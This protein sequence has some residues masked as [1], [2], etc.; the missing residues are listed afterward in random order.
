VEVSPGTT[1]GAI[2]S[3]IHLREIFHDSQV[4]TTIHAAKALE[5]VKEKPDRRDLS[6]MSEVSQAL[7]LHKPMEELLDY[8]MDIV[9]SQLPMDRSILMLWEG[10]PLQLIPKV[11][12]I[13]ERRLLNQKIL[14]SQS[15]VD[16]VIRDQLSVLTS[17]AM[18]DPRFMSRESII[19]SNIHSAMCVPLWNNKE[20]IGIIYSDR[21]TNPEKFTE[22]DLRLLTLL[23]NLAAVKIENAQLIENT[24]A[25]EKMEKEL[26]LASKIQKDFLPKCSPSLEHYEIEG[27][28]IP[29][30]QVGGDYFDYIEIDPVR[31]GI[32]IA[33]VSGKGVSASLL[34]ASLRAALYSEVHSRYKLS[35]MAL[36]LNGFVHRSSAP[37][38]FIT[39][40]F[41]E[42]DKETGKLSYVNAGHNPP[43]I[44]NAK[45]KVRRLESCG[46]CLGMFPDSTYE[47]KDASL[48][49]GDIALFFTDGVPDCRNKGN[50]E[51]TEQRLV[52]LVKD[53]RELSA[54]DLVQKICCEL[55]SFHSGTVAIDDMT[56]IIIKRVT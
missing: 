3:M 28:N 53:N 8:I 14:V 49:I 17:D 5:A 36:K 54:S 51:F 37:S 29:C 38:S 48:D 4:R 13:N 55:A 45:G 41:G 15:I 43:L 21:I 33:D 40:F 35:D 18:A 9:C 34:M 47:I 6:V 24:I 46:L 27:T 2:N 19:Q 12:R 52:N 26:E 50:A 56:L 16:M 11:V 1:S 22:E 25:K 32:V 30:Y 20:I 31:L 10:N 44:I 42:L 39:F 7:V 23:S